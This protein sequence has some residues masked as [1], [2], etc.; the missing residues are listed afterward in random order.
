MC[1]IGFTLYQGCIHDLL[2]M[3]TLLVDILSDPLRKLLRRYA[4]GIANDVGVVL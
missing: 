3:P 1:H 4:L 2:N